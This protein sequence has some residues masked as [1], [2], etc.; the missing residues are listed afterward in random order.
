MNK[1]REEAA[2]LAWMV[3]K[4]VKVIKSRHRLYG[5]V[6]VVKSVNGSGQIEIFMVDGDEPYGLSAC[7]TPKHVAVCHRLAEVEDS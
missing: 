6:G 1:C 7:I 2:S 4:Q 3:H 5:R